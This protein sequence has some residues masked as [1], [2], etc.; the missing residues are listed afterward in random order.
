MTTTPYQAV[1]TELAA[2]EN[3]LI[4][5]ATGTELQRRGVPM[6]QEAWCAPASASHPRILRTIHEDYIRAGARLI[7]ANTFAS[8]REIL[9]PVGLGDQF[10]QLNRIS[11][12]LAVE[13]RD[14]VAAPHP[15]LVAGSITHITPG[16][17]GKRLSPQHS[18]CA[19][20]EADCT[21]MA[22]IHKQ[23]G[24][25]LIIAEMMGDPDYAPCVIRA[26]Q[27][28]ELPVWVGLSVSGT[29][30]GPL[31]ACAGGAI[32]FAEVLAPI[33]ETGG[34]VMGIMH[35]EADLIEPALALLKQHWT[36]PL[37]AYPDCIDPRQPGD[38][39]VDLS[40]VPSEEIFVD[41]CRGWMRS[42]VQVLGGC[43][44]MSVSHI[45]ALSAYLAEMP[46]D[47]HSGHFRK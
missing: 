45:A 43:C 21:E 38:T 44:G 41:Y 36:G 27:A 11:V 25:D 7:T 37:L 26:A 47:H 42:G 8:T 9:E 18:D 23:A 32:P 12:E 39:D 24:C 5:G 1:M 46:G 34:D 28:N 31:T 33:V 40:R 35:S 2:G 17:G 3:L 20:F 29:S 22:A 14:R 30:A 16:G 10:V 4:D 19:R 15:V 6:A 13:A